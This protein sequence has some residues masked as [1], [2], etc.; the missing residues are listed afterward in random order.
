METANFLSNE[1]QRA[2]T[3]SRCKNNEKWL[4]IDL[5]TDQYGFE[6]SWELYRKPNGNGAPKVLFS[7][8]EYY[9]SFMICFQDLSYL[10][11][12]HDI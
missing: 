2:L 6:N 11:P 12:C 5:L 1:E 4:R 8:R 3:S 10:D 9:T 7:G